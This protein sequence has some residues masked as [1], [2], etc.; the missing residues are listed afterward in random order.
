MPEMGMFNFN[1]RATH[2]E[3]RPLRD[4]SDNVALGLS[5]QAMRAMAANNYMW[6]DEYRVFRGQYYSP[7]QPEL[8]R[9]PKTVD[10]MSPEDWV[11]VTPVTG[12]K[13]DLGHNWYEQDEES[14]KYVPVYRNPHNPLE[15]KTVSQMTEDD[16]RLVRPRRRQNQP[17]RQELAT[18]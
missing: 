7:G 3:M 13:S 6:N 11:T 9:V 10:Q 8:N 12:M 14:G 16:M 4:G 17:A 1:P 18:V 5:A 15:P 2:A